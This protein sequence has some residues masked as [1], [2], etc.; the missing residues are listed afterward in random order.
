MPSSRLIG[1]GVFL[2]GGI[3]LFAAGL[4]LI[5][6]R[7]G[8]FA[9]NFEVLAEFS[10]LAGLENGATVRV[11]G[12]DAGEVVQIHVPASPT[13]KFRVRARI[14]EE[15]H[16]V[17][18]SDSVASIQTQGLVGNKFLQIEGGTDQAP[19]AP[20]GSTILSR[21]PFDLEDVLRQMSETLTL[22]TDTV[23]MLRGEIQLAIRT[24]TEAGGQARDMIA[25]TR[26]DVE[27]IAG[28]SRRIIADMQQIVEDVRGGRGTVGKLFTD[29]SLYQKAREIAT[30]AEAVVANLKD[31][32]NETKLTIA[33]F[34]GRSGDA[35]QSA[36]AD[37]RQTLL[38]ARDAMSDLADSAE[39]LKRN[40]LLRGY[41]T[42]RGYFDLDDL[43]EEA[44]RSG[45]LE[46]S[47][48][49]ALRIWLGADV[50]FAPAANGELTLTPEG[51][52]R[53]ESAMSE[54]LEYPRSSPIVVEGYAP[55]ATADARYVRARARA[56]LVRNHLISTFHLDSSRVGLMPLGDRADGSPSGGPWD[57]I[58]I[59]IFVPRN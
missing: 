23:D 57:G 19:R 36:A 27:A 5:G 2:L 38:H 16:G 39:A 37:L 32:V 40:F 58:A 53:V 20:D 22:V 13:A 47:N 44:Y 33:E 4:F 49:R 8:L 14:R 50:L 3:A 48:R 15:L 6:D 56:A 46:G 11:A 42:R 55:G 26:D 29:D 18:R 1:V 51:R 17:V 43:D 24:V 35:R 45:A 21:E 9:Q 52:R 10:E 31:A 54:F 28:D 12:L 30:Q 59:A 25:A 34:R 41:F 7:R